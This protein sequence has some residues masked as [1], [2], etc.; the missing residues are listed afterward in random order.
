MFTIHYSKL[1]VLDQDEALDFYV[2]KLGFEVTADVD[3][4]SGRWLT[5]AA[6]DDPNH[7]IYLERPGPPATDEAT[8]TQV[9]DLL[10]RGALGFGIALRTD[11]CRKVS[12]TLRERGVEFTQEPVEHFYGVDCGI[13]DPFGNQIR[14]LER[15]Q[16]PSQASTTSS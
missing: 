13:R 8:A 3:Y 11:D 4:G 6:P 12:E 1:F 14:I 15:A 7:H 9:R 10:T 2:G 5:V 16:D